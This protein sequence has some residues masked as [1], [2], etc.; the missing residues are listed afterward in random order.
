MII[1]ATDGLAAGFAAVVSAGAPAAG[2]VGDGV[3]A[4]GA[5]ATGGGVGYPVC[6]A[7]ITDTQKLL[8]LIAE[9]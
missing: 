6:A 7:H 8:T 5:V 4:P 1:G 3:T 2:T 9:N